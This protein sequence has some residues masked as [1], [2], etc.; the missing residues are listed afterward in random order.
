MTD[1]LT[2]PA[3]WAAIAALLAAIGVI[4]LEAAMWQHIIEVVA[5]VSAIIGIIFAARDARDDSDN[6]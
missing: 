3:F 5:G 1:F 4:E 6:R 2:N